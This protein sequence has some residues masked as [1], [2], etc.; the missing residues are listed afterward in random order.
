MLRLI[1]IH[2]GK[3]RQVAVVEE[4]RLRLLRSF[5]SVYAIA[6]AAI[7]QNIN[8]STLIT[9]SM[10]T[11]T[12]DYD[13]VYLGKSNWR[14]MCPFDHPDDPAHTLVSGT[15]LTHLGS[16]A[17]RQARNIGPARNA[18]RIHVLRN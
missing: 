5:D 6:Q 11:Q 12:I 18:S 4:P 9:A 3:S 10:G 2:D 8:L 7:S 1:Q 15:G 16:A 17:N 14:L 13:E